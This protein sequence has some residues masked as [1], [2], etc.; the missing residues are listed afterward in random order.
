[1]NDLQTIRTEAAPLPAGHYSQAVVYGGVVYVAGLLALDPH[2]R[3]PVHGDA[4]EQLRVVVRHL[5]EIL[6]AAGSDLAHV[7]KTTVYISTMDDWNRV[8]AAYAALF[9][10]HRPARTIVPVGRL[11]FGLTVEL[12]AIA[13][14]GQEGR[15]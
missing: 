13:A 1:M 8:N 4:A 11:H 12:D 3:E 9:G 5:A 10:D 7:L 2:T 14:L 6:H 15:R